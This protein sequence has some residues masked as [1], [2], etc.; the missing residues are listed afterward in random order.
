[1]HQT[2]TRL[3]AAAALTA[4]LAAVS[5]CANE[6]GAAGAKFEPKQ[7]GHLIVILVIVLLIFGPGKLPEL[8][9]L[10][11]TFLSGPIS[12]I[13]PPD[14][15]IIESTELSGADAFEEVINLEDCS[16][17]GLSGWGWQDNGWGLDVLGPL[18]YFSTSGTHTLRLQPREDGLSLDQIVLSPKTYLTV[19]PGAVV[20]DTTILAKQ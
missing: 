4:V 9:E 7:P 15:V 10:P 1:M 14:N 11:I 2:L 16:G 3:L 12:T 5:A 8:G 6:E 18:V 13:R 19:A 17:C 20:N